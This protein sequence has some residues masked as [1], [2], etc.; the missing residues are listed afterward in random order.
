VSGFTNGVVLNFDYFPTGRCADAIGFSTYPLETCVRHDAVEEFG[1][2]LAMVHE[3]LRPDSFC[4]L[5]QGPAG[6][7]RVG[8]YDSDSIM[9]YCRGVLDGNLSTLDIQGLHFFYGDPNSNS[10]KKDALV[11]QGSNVA[12][13]LMGGLYTKFGTVAPND[14]VHDL[15]PRALT[16]TNWPGWPIS[17]P[18]SGGADA[19]IDYGNGKAYFFSGNQYLRYD[20]ATDRVDA[21]PRTLPGGWVNWPATWTS[22]DAAVRWSNG[23]VYMF[24]GGQY[25]R[26][27]SGFTVDAGYPLPIAGNWN[28][29][30]TTGFDYVL[31]WPNNKAY[32][33]KGVDYARYNLSTDT[34]DAGYPAKIVGRWPG[35][36]F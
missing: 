7:T 26:I 20:K 34:T 17:A 16:N 9:N 18:W 15:Y 22:V 29:P 24:R 8:Q 32:F 21:A 33:F 30:F 4:L 25:L 12:Y 28:I 31:I 23:K 3:A 1:H 6:D 5:Q 27:T 19:S 2:A 36:P 14:H 13:F 35:V 11:W 10:L